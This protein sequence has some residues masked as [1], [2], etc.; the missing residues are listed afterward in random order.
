MHKSKRK[1]NCVDCNENTKLEHYFTN[2]EVWFNEAKMPETG[3]LCIGCLEKR[4]NRTLN[5]NDFTSAHINNPRR[6]AMTTR[7]ADRITREA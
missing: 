7:L 1:W 5:K 2:A 4:I 6:Y 3:M